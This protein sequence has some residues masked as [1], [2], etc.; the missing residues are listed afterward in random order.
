MHLTALVER[1]DHVCCRYRLAAFRPSLERAGH[2]LEFRPWPRS[3][4]SRL[5]LARTLRNADA[6][7]L[8]RR[9]L[10]GWLLHLLRCEARL[11]LFDFDDAVFL[12]DSY[13][14]KGLASPR[15]L[16]RFAAVVETADIVVAGNDFLREQAAR[17]TDPARVHTIPTCVDPGRY[18]LAEHARQGDGVEL[19][20]IGSA[21]TLR[22]LEL[23]RS[24]LEN[25]GRCWPGLRLRLICDRFL[26]FRHL[27]VVPCLWSEATEAADLA[28]AD[29][30]IS[31]LPDDAWSRGKC[32]L[33]VLQYMAAGLPVVANPVGVQAEMV[34]HGETGFL[35]R[36]ADEWAEAVGRLAHDPALRRRMGRAGRRRVEADFS[37][38]RGAARWVALLD[39][40]RQKKGAA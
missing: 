14:P 18:P 20:W 27:P 19:V 25:L 7:I 35:V 9:L 21:S 12:R 31:W 13:S 5:R 37:V 17:W 39:G 10:P 28:G 36:T 16:Q 22:G 32:G 34:R 2:R 23:I 11:L 33:K 15:R 4:W 1:P 24:L 8:Q 30:G 3:C 26:Q 40:L 29:I 6:V 38:A